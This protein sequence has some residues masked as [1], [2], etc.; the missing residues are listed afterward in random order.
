MSYLDEIADK[1]GK[2]NYHKLA[3]INNPKLHEFIARYVKLC[4]PDKI[5]V[6]TD[7]PEDIA[8]IREAAI[9][10]GEEFKLAIEGHTAPL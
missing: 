10:N 1:L 9:R 3:K 2:E 7:S 8:Y 5:Y 4:N 6:C